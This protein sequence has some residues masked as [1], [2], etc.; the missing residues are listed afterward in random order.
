MIILGTV[1]LYSLFATAIMSYIALATPIGPWI[2]TTLVLVSMLIFAARRTGSVG[3]Y[4]DAVMVTTAA[5]AIGGIIAT[6]MAFSLPTLYFVAPDIFA[7]WM[8]DGVWFALRC[9]AFTLAA[10]SFGMMVAEYY[11]SSLFARTDLKFP[12]G[13]LVYTT[14]AAAGNMFR[15]IELL[16]GFL[17]TQC[18][19]YW[20]TIGMRGAAMIRL[21]AQYT[22]GWITL[23]ALTIPVGQLPLYLSVGFVTGHIMMVPLSVGIMLKLLLLDPFYMLY[24]RYL[25][26]TPLSHNEYIFACCSGMVLY[27]AVIHMFGLPRSIRKFCTEQRAMPLATGGL[28]GY[29]WSRRHAII[30]AVL[31]VTSIVLSL[32]GFSPLV[33]LYIMVSATVWIYQLLIIAG[34]LGIAPLGRF[35]TFMMVPAMALF[36]LDMVQITLI[37]AFVEIAGGVASDTLFGR[38]A[39]MLAGVS[40]ARVR[41]YQWIGL[42]ISSSIVGIILWLLIGHFGLGAGGAALPAT[43]A[44]G[45]ALL[46]GFKHFDPYMILFGMVIGWSIAQSTINPAM[47]LG[48]I[49]MPPILSLML[50]AGGLLSLCARRSER[51]YPLCSGV[52][53]GN[54]VWMVLQACLGG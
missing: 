14:V 31:C 45:R 13:E 35:A 49:L 22:I 11:E 53:A 29:S 47:I 24:T 40:A 8:S 46:I 30:V 33:Q 25:I 48:G 12:I 26:D 51:Y 43:K 28:V 54:S 39:A 41:Y 16:V 38:K 6:A 20:Y 44:A 9:A 2:E 10:A 4:R 7:V 32:F 1:V 23:P 5:G 19:L 21:M 37:A 34:T 3:A 27:G 42:G 18:F 36:S 15:S 52:S 17:L 50:I